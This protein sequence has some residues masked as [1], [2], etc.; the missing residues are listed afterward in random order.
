MHHFEP[1]RR[2]KQPPPAAAANAT[3]ASE[4]PANYL[5]MGCDAPAL[6]NGCH[7][8]E[9]GVDPRGGGGGG[10]DMAVALNVSIGASVEH[11]GS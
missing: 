2:H 1:L 3:A 7:R 11:G 5:L 10:G 8:R 4:S 6:L 9:G